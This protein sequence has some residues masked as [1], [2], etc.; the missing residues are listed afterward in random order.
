MACYCDQ[1]VSLLKLR[2]GALMFDEILTRFE[3]EGPLLKHT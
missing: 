3:R 2:D 1:G